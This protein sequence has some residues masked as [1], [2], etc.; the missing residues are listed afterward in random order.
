MRCDSAEW[1]WFKNFVTFSVQR[2]WYFL[3]SSRGFCGSTRPSRE[4]GLL[5]AR[6]KIGAQVSGGDGD[7]GR[8]FR[9][10]LYLYTHPRKW[11]EYIG[12][13]KCLLQ[14][15]WKFATYNR[16]YRR[17]IKCQ[18]FSKTFPIRPLEEIRKIHILL[19]VKL[20]ES[21]NLVMYCRC[22]VELRK[23]WQIYLRKLGAWQVE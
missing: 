3:M 1:R 11:D 23:L 18:D 8:C 17:I 14:F 7:T 9:V 16:I 12:F 22:Q 2:F 4:A 10:V 20:L 13:P 15:G 6:T 5:P 19:L 21:E